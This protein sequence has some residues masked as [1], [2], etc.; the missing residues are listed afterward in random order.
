[1]TQLDENIYNAIASL[2]SKGNSLTAESRYDDARQAF[3]EALGLLPAP[4]TKWPTATWLYMAIGDIYFRQANFEKM[5]DSFENAIQCPGGE[6]NPF[7]F[8]RLGQAYLETGDQ[9]KAGEYLRSAYMGGALAV[10]Q[11][12]NPKYLEFLKTKMDM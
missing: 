11:E 5:R 1:M 9:G 10:M 4:H 12:E 3:L 8:L 2:V 6:T 7:V